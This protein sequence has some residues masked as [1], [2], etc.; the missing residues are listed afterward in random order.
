MG[1]YF[2]EFENAQGRFRCGLIIFGRLLPRGGLE[3]FGRELTQKFDAVREV[4]QRLVG[5]AEREIDRRGNLLR[6]GFIFLVARSVQLFESLGLEPPL[7]D[8]NGQGSDA[9]GL[10]RGEVKVAVE[11]F[12][13]A[14]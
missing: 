2:V 9:V 5:A 12:D 3:L 14:R 10:R 8:E 7:Q 13:Q 6:G 11:G 1:L 4:R